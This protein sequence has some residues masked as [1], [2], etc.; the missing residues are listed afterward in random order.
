MSKKLDKNKPYGLITG[1]TEGRVYEQ[2]GQYFTGTGEP[3]GAQEPKAE[4]KPAKAPKA[5]PRADVNPDDPDGQLAA[6]MGS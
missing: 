3:W 4:A 6:Q 2:D 5:A 1:D